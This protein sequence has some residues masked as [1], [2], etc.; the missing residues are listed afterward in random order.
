[1]QAPVQHAEHTM[2]ELEEKFMRL[3]EM[4]QSTPEFVELYREVDEALGAVVSPA[5]EEDVA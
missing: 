1:M 3:L 2:T 4:D 5:H